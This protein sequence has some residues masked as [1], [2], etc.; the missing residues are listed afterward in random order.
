M[1]YDLKQ[2][3][4][5]ADKIRKEFFSRPLKISTSNCWKE[6][7]DLAGA[8]AAN[9]R[10]RG[11]TQEYLGFY[12]Q[13]LQY[14]VNFLI[15]NEVNKEQ[16][17]FI[18]LHLENLDKVYRQ[19]SPNGQIKA[20]KPI[21]TS[22]S[23]SNN[24]TSHPNLQSRRPQALNAFQLKLTTSPSFAAL[25]TYLKDYLIEDKRSHTFFCMKFAEKRK[26]YYVDALLVKLKAQTDKE[27]VSEVLREFYSGKN[28]TNS[29]Y[30]ILNTGQD[31][32][33]WLFGI[34][35]T[36]LSKIDAIAKSVDF[37]TQNVSGVRNLFK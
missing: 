35:T 6:Y 11:P 18:N 21:A 33:T 5:F 26:A 24:K 23:E 13:A 15:R 3:A 32:F 17:Q 30:E 16:Q 20:P 22:S 28:C 37:N 29:R 14:A 2:V 31:L 8:L 27:G 9:I 36:T 25:E 4:T 12:A 10:R 7:S 34:K 19:L 1:T